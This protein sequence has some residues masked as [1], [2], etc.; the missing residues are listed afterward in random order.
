MKIIIGKRFFDDEYK[1]II[2]IDKISMSVVDCVLT[3]IPPGAFL[4]EGIMTLPNG[5]MIGFR[6]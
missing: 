1:K 4:Y 3:E 5:S 6:I 2:A